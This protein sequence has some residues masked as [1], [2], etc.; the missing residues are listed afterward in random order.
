MSISSTSSCPSSPLKASGVCGQSALVNVEEGEGLAPVA[1]T[2]P[3]VRW[4]RRTA[5]HSRA[6]LSQLWKVSGREA[7][8]NGEGAELVKLR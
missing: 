3:S 8:R 7:S 4:W 2:I 6:P 5:T 1:V